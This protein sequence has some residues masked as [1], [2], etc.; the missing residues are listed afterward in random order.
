MHMLRSVAW[1][2]GRMTRSTAMG[3]PGGVPELALA[4]MHAAHADGYAQVRHTGP[5]G[6]AR[7]YTEFAAVHCEAADGAARTHLR[8]LPGKL[9]MH[10][11][12]SCAV[13]CDADDPIARRPDFRACSYAR[14]LRLRPRVVLVSVGSLV[15]I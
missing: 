1:V 14:M 15:P 12:S 4:H 13:R 8:M 3:R 9:R 5:S 10:T 11:I 7:T 6:C 2:A